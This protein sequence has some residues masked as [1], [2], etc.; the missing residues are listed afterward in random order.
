MTNDEKLD[1]LIGVIYEKALDPGRW[2]E[3]LG[4]CGQY[5]G[6]VDAQMVTI[7]K[8][9]KTPIA[10][11]YA[12]TE[13]S[14]Q[15]GTDYIDHY[16]TID[17]RA[18]ILSGRT[19][20]DWLCCNQVFDQKFVDHN[21]FY[22]DFFIA[23]G[24]RFALS[25]CVDDNKEN[26][27]FLGI[28]RAI[29]QRPFGV[30]EQ[31]A[32]QRFSGHLQR[33]LRLQKHTQALQ[34][35]AELGARA[36]DVLTL[37][38]LIVNHKGV[39]LHL[40]ASAENL[41]NSRHSGLTCKTGSL[42]TTDQTNKNHLTA[43]IAD[44]TGYPAVGGAMFLYGEQT[45]QLFISPLPA[46]SPF[47]QDWQTPLALVL[48]ME[49][50]TKLSALNALGKLYNLTPAE[51]RVASALLTGDSAEEYGQK[52]GVSQNTVRTQLKSLFRKT[53]TS[54]QSQLVALLSRVPPLQ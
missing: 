52:A 5:A 21:E 13:F 12:E 47:A 8:K 20:G 19:V 27:S 24:A 28:M 43:L 36:I 1:H 4:L 51:L 44:A 49:S 25:A 38:M 32:A 10:T 23:N 26:Q 11:V 31:Q 40:N 46:A 41:L 9:F 54:R 15:A 14:Q 33:A 34:N 45:Q 50:G 37:S 6:G 53:G 35:K 22:Q 16:I 30:I 29:G 2:K 39:I 48:V 42:F 7:E 3:A 17:P 18:S